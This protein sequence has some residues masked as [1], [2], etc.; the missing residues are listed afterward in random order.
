[1]RWLLLKDLQIL[2]RSK[3]LVSLLIIYPIAIATLMGFALS[4]GPDKPRVAFLNEVP[5]NRETIQLGDQEAEHPHVHR[6]AA[7]GDRDRAGDQPPGGAGE[8]ALGRRAGGDDH[9][10]GLHPEAVERRLLARERRGRLQR[11]RAQAVVRHLDDH[12][13]ARRRE[14][15]A[16]GGGQPAGQRLHQGAARRRRAERLRPALPDPRAAQLLAA[17]R[18]DARRQ[19][20][21]GDQATARPGPELRPPRARQHGARDRRAQHRAEAG[22]TSSRPC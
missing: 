11:R 19:P 14:R 17:D 1:M 22:R 12:V 10:V 20:D 18:P 16:V 15:R 8:G 9:P 13:E 6:R 3:L 5:A 4:S 21:G 7:Q 2:R